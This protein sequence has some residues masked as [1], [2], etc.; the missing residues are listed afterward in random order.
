MNSYMSRV[1]SS[2]ARREGGGGLLMTASVPKPLNGGY[3]VRTIVFR[4]PYNSTRT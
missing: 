3:C 2:Q 4:N 1:D